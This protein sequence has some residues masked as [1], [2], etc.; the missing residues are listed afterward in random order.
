VVRVYR[1]PVTTWSL[2]S[3]FLA[4]PLGVGLITYRLLDSEEETV[5]DTQWCRQFLADHPN[6]GGQILS[7]TT[8]TVEF[9]V[10]D[11]SRTLVP[12]YIL[13]H[14]EE[15]DLDYWELRDS[16]GRELT[17]YCQRANRQPTTSP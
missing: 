8:P 3:L 12:G 16:D 17:L 10:P 13:D 11:A 7:L 5:Y 4:L 1:Q 14:A 2:V 6:Q 15:P 9:F